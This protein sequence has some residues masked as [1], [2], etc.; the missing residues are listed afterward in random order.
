M[1]IDLDRAI[2]LKQ[3]LYSLH[4]LVL[5]GKNISN[6]YYI[7]ERSY[8]IEHYLQHIPSFLKECR[9]LDDFIHKLT[10]VASGSGSWQARREFIENEFRDFLNFLEFGKLSK[11]STANIESGTINIILQKDVFSHVQD[12]LN[13]KHYFNS[14]EEAYKIV[15]EKLRDITGKEKAHEAF[16]ES[17]YSLIFGHEPRNETE[18]DFFDGVKFLHMAIQKLRNEKAHT[19]A[20]EIDKNL[21]IHY[22]VLASLAYDLIDRK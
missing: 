1:N 4:D 13:S 12:L 2:Q 15:R 10:Q 21:A 9:T 7:Q 5:D 17:N 16:K 22:L 20:K 18:K 14:V 6:N 11:Y 3:R 19:P 8:F